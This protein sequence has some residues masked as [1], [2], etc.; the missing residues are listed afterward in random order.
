MKRQIQHVTIETPVRAEDHQ[1]ALVLLRRQ[2]QRIGNLC[3][4]V[5]SGNVNLFFGRERLLQTA[6]IAALGRGNAPLLAL[7][8]PQLSIDH[9]YGLQLVLRRRPDLGFKGN[10]LRRPPPEKWT[11]QFRA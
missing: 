7:L 6:E 3:V 8:L 9:V 4:R 5:Q 1:H 10:L 2:L 11:A